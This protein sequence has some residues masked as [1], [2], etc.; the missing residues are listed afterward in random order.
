A[1]E[2]TGS[3]SQL[4]PT[5]AMDSGGNFV[6]A[7]EDQ[8]N[9]YYRD[10]YF[11][12]YSSSGTVQGINTKAND[13]LGDFGQQNPKIAMDFVGNFIIVWMDSRSGGNPD[14]YYQRYNSGGIAQGINTEA[15]DTGSSSHYRPTIASDALGNFVIAWEDTRNGNWDIYF[16]R[17]NSNGVAQGINT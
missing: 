16:Q 6:I 3:A 11:Q 13:D 5:F 15:N 17:Y 9:S 12:R 1:Y 2:A 8:R 10:I 4:Y 14:I 7:W